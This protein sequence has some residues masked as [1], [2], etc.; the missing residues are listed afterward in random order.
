MIAPRPEMDSTRGHPLHPKRVSI[1]G[2]DVPGLLMALALVEWRPELA[3]TVLPTAPSPTPAVIGTTP[4]TTAFLFGYLGLDP[5]RFMRLVQPAMRLGVRFEWGDRAPWH[6]NEVFGEADLVDAHAH[7][8]HLLRCGIASQLIESARAPIARVGDRTI[9]LLR[10]APFGWHLERDRL[11]PLLRDRARAVGIGL[12]V[13]PVTDVEAK[14]GRIERVLTSDGHAH[15]ADLWVDASGPRSLLLGGALAVP[16]DHHPSSLPADTVLFAVRER[17]AA[18][19][20]FTTVTT[21]GAGWCWRLPGR[22]VEQLAY[23]HGSHHL[24]PAAAAA[25]LA[26]AM[27]GARDLVFAPLAPGRHRD[28]LSGNV[29][30]I[31]DAYGVHDPLD[32]IDH[33]LTLTTILRVLAL[34]GGDGRDAHRLGAQLGA[35][36]DAARWLLATRY[37]FNRRVSSPFWQE[38]HVAIDWSGLEGPVRDYLEHGAFTSRPASAGSRPLPD[39][40]ALDLTLLGQRIVPERLTPATTPAEWRELTAMRETVVRACL[41]EPEALS[42]LIDSPELLDDVVH[43]ERSWCR[44]LTAEMQRAVPTRGRSSEALGSIARELGVP[45]L[46][47]REAAAMPDAFPTSPNIDFGKLERRVPEV[48]LRP[49]DQAQLAE[50]LQLCVRRRMPIKIRGAGHSSGGQTLTDEGAVIDLRWLKRIIADAPSDE[51]IRVESG[52]WWL[53]LCGH[54]RPQGRRPPV[55]TDNWRVSIGGTLAVG[56]FGDSTHREGLQITS[57][58]ELTVMTLDGTRHRVRPGDD[59]F[60]WSLAGRGQLGI[61][62]EV[63]LDTVRRSYDLE[64]RV[65]SWRTLVDFLA[66]SRRISAEGRFDWLRARMMWTPGAPVA[67]AAGHMLNPAG[68]SPPEAAR[69]FSGLIA[70]LGPRERVDLFA[71]GIEDPP[72]EHW[73]FASPGVELIV[74]MDADGLAALREVHRRVSTSDIARYMPRGSSIMVLPGS[75]A[76]RFPMAPL[77]ATDAVVLVA[78]R[79]EV[80][81][82]DVPRFVASMRELADFV[83]AAGGK[84]YLMGLEPTRPGWLRDQLGRERYDR[85]VALKAKWDPEGLLNPG[86]LV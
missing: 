76:I 41:P 2:D 32:P 82:T 10:D 23:V 83:V 8:G 30:A 50:C 4:P 49:K 42:L 16:F 37:R 1:V 19:A 86:L 22:D 75:D 44:L 74:P 53:E 73:A 5:H 58:R 55:L 68:A 84:L 51:R 17:A 46:L 72:E 71:K 52:L 79:P 40:R 70:Q 80:P 13:A 12:S 20:P 28:F 26:D 29:V 47:R 69:D 81:V 7:D 24:A 77:P 14:E 85:L 43:G 6:F 39:A 18:S 34:L 65:L 25:E 78:I 61:V 33:Q 3:V 62:T 36:W 15:I 45:A 64:A 66:D 48:V 59:L 56:G 63:V 38:A 67:A 60:D 57:A 35:D 9:S 11:M 31:G 54:L 27:P 21:L